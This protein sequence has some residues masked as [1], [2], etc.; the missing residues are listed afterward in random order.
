MQIQQIQQVFKHT[1][2]EKKLKQKQDY[3]SCLDVRWGRVL[4]VCFC[5]LLLLGLLDLLDLLDCFFGLLGCL[6]FC[7]FR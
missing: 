3:A 6:V 7:F 1:H 4:F 2:T 5:I